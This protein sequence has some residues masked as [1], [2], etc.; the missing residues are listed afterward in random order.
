MDE[1]DYDGRTAVHLAA[2]EGH[3]V[4][5]KSLSNIKSSLYQTFF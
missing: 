5:Q 1:C 4:S 2:A 3:L